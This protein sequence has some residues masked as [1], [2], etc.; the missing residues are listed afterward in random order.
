M[1]RDRV[2]DQHARTRHRFWLRLA[3]MVALAVTAVL[4]GNGDGRGAVGS[5]SGGHEHHAMIPAALAQ[6]GF[7]A[8]FDGSPT[9]PLPW[10]PM[11]WSVVA[12]DFDMWNGDGQSFDAMAASHSS[13]CGAP[14][15]QHTVSLLQDAVFLC[16]GHVM[17]AINGGGGYAAIYLTPPALADFPA[18]EAVVR[19][20]MSTL[21][22]STR[23]WTDLWLTPFEESMVL[24][25]D[26]YLPA[27]QGPPR[28]AIHV[29]MDNAVGGT[30]FR[31]ETISGFAAQRLSG[32]STPYEQVLTP[33]A[34]RRDT[35][36]LRVSRT[37]VK[38]GMPAYNL[39]W[40]DTAIADQGWSRGVVQLAH[41]SYNP[42]KGDCGG[43]TCEATWHWDNVSI[44]PFAPMA[45]I[46]SSPRWAVARPG[47][48]DTLLFPSAAPTGASLQFAAV[49]LI[50]YSY[51]GGATWTR[52]AWQPS[53]RHLPEQFSSYLIPIPAGQTSV[54]FRGFADQY[55]GT[56]M[57]ANASI[58]APGAAPPPGPTSTPTSAPVATATPTPGAQQTITFDDL[59]GQNQVLSGQYPVGV[60]DWGTNNWYHSAPWQ[61]L[62][63][64]SIGFNGYGP[65]SEPFSFVTPRRLVS[66]LAYNGGAVSSTVTLACAGQP[67]K[68]V[69]LAPGQIATINTGWTGTCSTVTVGSS[70]GW[71]V[72][73]DNLVIQ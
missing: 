49:G 61:Q 45:V 23:D 42:T 22:G 57:V 7:L 55:I 3:L 60:I 38:F 11:D 5:S 32:I 2:H 41:H 65:T 4:L 72:N 62:P 16:N 14:P 33:D 31:A 10:Q 64:K 52:A 37:H 19:F 20:D 28:R 59:A 44:A 47:G 71:D 36:E 58:V 30:F 21:R 48:P 35:F 18:G 15:A 73:F 29:L 46:P 56:W 66:V 69:V 1:A 13:T 68:T 24:P 34:A 53:S 39:W 63:T 50:D 67:T 70:N 6:G 9:A 54:K 17:T 27:Y 26:D 40:V 51:N 12:N 8:T 43:R 25:L